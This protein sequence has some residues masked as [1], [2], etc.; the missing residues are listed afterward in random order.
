MKLS[1]KTLPALPEKA[2]RQLPV[3]DWWALPEKVLQF[4]TGVLLRGLPDFF[5]NKANKQGVFNGRIV[6]VK[7]T[8]QGDIKAFAEQDGLFTQCIRGIAGGHQVSEDV[9]NA[10]ISRVLTATSQ[11]QEILDCAANPDMQLVISNTTEVGIVYVEEDIRQSPPASF[12]AKLLA[13]LYQRYQHFKG[14][15]DKGMV[16]IPTELIPD[17]G[18]KL[19][20]ILEQL[21]LFN[22]L[23][24]AFIQWLTQHNYC[25]NSLVDCI[26]PGAA[27][28]AADYEDELLIMTEV[29]RLWAI[30]TDQEIVK[31][32]LPFSAVDAGFVLSPDINV[33]RELKLRLLNATHTLSCGLA[34][35]AGLDTVK[36]AMSSEPMAAYMEGLMMHE[37]I[38]AITDRHIRSDAAIRFAYAVLDRFRNPYIEHRWL[39]ICSQYT[40]KMKM[41]VL[42]VLLQYYERTGHVPALISLGFAAHLLFMRGGASYSITDEFATLYQHA[43]ENATPAEVVKNTLGNEQIWGRDLAAIPGFTQAVTAMLQQ[44]E[45]KGAMIYLEHVAT[46]ITLS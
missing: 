5:I 35:L 46:E 32:R 14:D 40:S 3:G 9:I 36:A 45:Q 22:Q 38:P 43:W 6:M 33:F 42:P 10:A 2:N 4:G 34:F 18:G 21:A 23:E 26:V 13:F 11:W 16:I 20:G 12:P 44:L 41:R 39:S 24:P 31:A 7:S 30:E 1:R 15:P 28:I 37:I 8:A 27:D 29:Y 19:A 17:N 25:C